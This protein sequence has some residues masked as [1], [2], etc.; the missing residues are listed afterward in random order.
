MGPQLTVKTQ[1]PAAGSQA[2][3]DATITL[4]SVKDGEEAASTAEG[5]SGR[6][7][8]SRQGVGLF[9]RSGGI[10]HLR[11]RG[12]AYLRDRGE[13]RLG[14]AQR[15]GLLKQGREL[16]AELEGVCPGPGALGAES[17]RRWRS[18]R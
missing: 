7:C 1:K 15:C 9:R 10:E 13:I 11:Q 16:V 4:C 6:P 3:L 8:T 2:S 17:L 12:A 14:N 5:E 18:T